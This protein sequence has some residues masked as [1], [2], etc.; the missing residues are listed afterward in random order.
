MRTSNP[1]KFQIATE[2]GRKKERK[3]ERKINKD[4]WEEGGKKVN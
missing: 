2:E 3:K 1:T 4:R